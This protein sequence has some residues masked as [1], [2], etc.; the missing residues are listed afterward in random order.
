MKC[1]LFSYYFELL[2]S[3]RRSPIRCYLKHLIPQILTSHHLFVI[4]S[5]SNFCLAPSHLLSQLELLSLH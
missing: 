1:H 2:I 3:N 5:H 4:L